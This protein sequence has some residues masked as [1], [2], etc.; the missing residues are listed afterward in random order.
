MKRNVVE[1]E[2]KKNSLMTV[3]ELIILLDVIG[4]AKSIRSD[5]L[6]PTRENE[7]VENKKQNRTET[8]R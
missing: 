4:L 8:R 1:K 2:A 5:A 3:Y 7:T 6:G